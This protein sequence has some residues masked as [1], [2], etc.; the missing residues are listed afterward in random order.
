VG[1]PITLEEAELLPKKLADECSA[2]VDELLK[3]DTWNF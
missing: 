1:F 3:D 2:V